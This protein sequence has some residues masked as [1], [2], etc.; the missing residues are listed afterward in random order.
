ME[1]R[2]HPAYWHRVASVFT[3]AAA[4]QSIPIVGSL[5]IAR[6]YVPAEFGS[7]AVW[8]G[9][10]LI[11]TLFL[12]ARLEAA[13]GLVA[14]GVERG[15]L[16]AATVAVVFVLGVLLAFGIWLVLGVWPEGV[17][18]VPAPLVWWLVPM[19]AG[20]ALSAVWQ[21]WAANNGHIRTLTLIR[22]AQAF[23]VTL[24][25][26][27]VGFIN[28][29]AEALAVAQVVGTWLAVMVAVSMLPIWS[30]FPRTWADLRA[31]QIE[32]WRHYWRFPLLALP[33]DMINTTAAQLPVILLGSRYGIEVSGYFAMAA[34]TMGAPL[35][36]L[37]GAVRDVFIRD[38]GVEMR[39]NGSCVSVYRRTF[40][41]LAA[42]SALLVVGTVL[43]AEPAFA[44]VFGNQW[45]IAGT[46]A[47]WLI[48][49]YALRF[50]ASPLSYTFYLAQKQNVDLVWQ[51]LLLIM[52][53]TVLHSFESYRITLIAYGY[54]YAG[55]YIIY[56]YL[57]RRYSRQPGRT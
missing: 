15:R 27:A 5:L 29:S 41:V 30:F 52:V 32:T 25:Q 33:G 2:G 22:L 42:L 6:L 8:L 40:R 34:R 21:S 50:V 31:L 11:V 13:F 54:G 48:P 18:G 17:F 49:L 1:N 3:G 36:V 14:D 56:L 45:R 16:V 23:C 28:P 20:A 53:V 57:S 39:A 55:M 24:L 19:S 4:A 51:I 10:S 7:F 47:V 38:A 43:L 26:I 35:A 44:L 37:G 9:V 12:S 46:M